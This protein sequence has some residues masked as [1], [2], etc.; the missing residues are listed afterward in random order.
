MP[1]TKRAI[2]YSIAATA[3]FLTAISTYACHTERTKR[4]ARVQKV[5]AALQIG[6]TEQQVIQALATA[7]IKHNPATDPTGLGKHHIIIVPTRDA[8][9]PIEVIEYT[10]NIAGGGHLFNFGPSAV[11]ITFD[12]NGIVTKID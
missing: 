5:K 6:M 10:T 8:P 7:G 11:I 1:N 12:N 3:L 9:S 2:L 4:N